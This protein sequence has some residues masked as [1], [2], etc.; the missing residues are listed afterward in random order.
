[1]SVPLFPARRDLLEFSR[2]RED[3]V[4]LSP[5]PPG[6]GR[7]TTSA[8]AACGPP[9]CDPASS[10]NNLSASLA[11]L[12]RWEDA[13]AAIEEAAQVYR[14]LAARWPDAYDHRLEQSLRPADWLQHRESDASPVGT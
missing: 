1:M 5:P 4:L 3:D 12:G 13:L 14:E 9:E 11:D 6:S 10:L 2:D 7:R 8:S